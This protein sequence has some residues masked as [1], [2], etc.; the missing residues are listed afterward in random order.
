MVFGNIL[1]SHMIMYKYTTYENVPEMVQGQ[2]S[3][4]RLQIAFGSF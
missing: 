4:S 3:I 1:L 2:Q